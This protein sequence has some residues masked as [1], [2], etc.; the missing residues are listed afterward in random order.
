MG[1]MCAGVERV[2]VVGVTLG[3]RL[4]IAFGTYTLRAVM[5]TCY[6]HTTENTPDPIRTLKLSSVG[7]G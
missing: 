3:T 6:G 7:P 2:L 1:F 5:L 4:Q